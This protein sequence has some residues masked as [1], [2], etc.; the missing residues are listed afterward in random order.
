MMAAAPTVILVIMAVPMAVVVM[1]MTVPTAPT[2]VVRVAAMH[3]AMTTT[4]MM[5]ATAM[6]GQGRA[7]GCQGCQNGRKNCEFS[8]HLLFPSALD[9]RDF[10]REDLCLEMLPVPLTQ[11]PHLKFCD[12]RQFVFRGRPRSPGSEIG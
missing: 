8:K 7:W 9:Q 3:V 1:G 6:L 10:A 12:A 4:T 5:A 2:F 11:S